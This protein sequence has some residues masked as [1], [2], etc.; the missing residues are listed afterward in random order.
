VTGGR[1]LLG[2]LFLVSTVA[3]GSANVVY[4]AFLPDIATPDERDAVSSKGWA[5]GYLGGGLLL[6]AN[7][8]LF[9]LADAGQPRTHPPVAAERAP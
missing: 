8:V 9:R 4:A 6:A 1:Y 7:L 5:F 2:V 3:F